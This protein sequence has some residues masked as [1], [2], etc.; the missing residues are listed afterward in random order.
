MPMTD[1]YLF[2]QYLPVNMTLDSRF[3]LTW[4]RDYYSGH[5]QH[6]SFIRLFFL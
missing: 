4:Y 6:H 2:G 1:N 3:H 5:R